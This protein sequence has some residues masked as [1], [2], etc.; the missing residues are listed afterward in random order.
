MAARQGTLGISAFRIQDD[1]IPQP[2]AFSNE[3]QGGAQSGPTLSSRDA[4]PLYLRQF[5]MFYTV[6]NDS[7]NNGTY[8][9]KYGK[10]SVNL[11]DNG[12]WD[13]FAGVAGSSVKKIDQ[14]ILNT[15]SINLPAN[16]ILY[17][18]LVNAAADLPAA[19]VGYT[20]GQEDLV[21]TQDMPPGFNPFIKGIYIPTPTTIFFAGINVQSTCSA[22]IFQF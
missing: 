15:G 4:I 10:V 7:N 22:I 21:L 6:Y 19:L 1:T 2:A 16:C 20:N 17:M 5:G 13:L 8:I 11:I 14:V 12:N 3:I 18:I 9:L